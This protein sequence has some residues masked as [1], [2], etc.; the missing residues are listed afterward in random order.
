MARGLAATAALAALVSVSAQAS[1]ALPWPMAG[2]DA[3]H[4]GVGGLPGP[5]ALLAPTASGG[6]GGGGGGSAAVALSTL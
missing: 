3:Q 5:A 1:I 6:G 4:S 2:H